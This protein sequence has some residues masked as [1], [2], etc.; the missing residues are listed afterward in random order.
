MVRQIR[1]NKP[2]RQI[3]VVTHNPN[4]VVNGDAEMLQVLDFKRGQCRVMQAQAA[5]LQ[6]QSMRDEVCNV[7]EGGR[8]AFQR[9]DRR[10]G[11]EG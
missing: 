2:H 9:R 1:A 7:M 3:V 6:D 5:S 11:P 4:V 8:E 10:L